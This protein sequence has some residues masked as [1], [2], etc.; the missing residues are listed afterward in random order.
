MLAATTHQELCNSYKTKEFPIP[1]KSGE[2]GN[3][4]GGSWQVVWEE[5]LHPD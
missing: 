1:G 2:G 4:E 3:R 5:M